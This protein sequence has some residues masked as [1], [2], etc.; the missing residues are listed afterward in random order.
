MSLLDALPG[1][2]GAAFAPLFRDA[3]ILTDGRRVPD[4]Q[5]GFTTGTATST[6]C[7]ALVDSF[8]DIRKA[9]AGIP[10]NDRKIIILGSTLTPGVIP[11]V[12]CRVRV[13][14]RDWTAVGVT[15]DPAGATYEVQGR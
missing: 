3:S 10:E 5:G 14:G 8:S 4:G 6:P 15:R 12:G 11:T 7:K 13:D 9:A 2:F 1:V